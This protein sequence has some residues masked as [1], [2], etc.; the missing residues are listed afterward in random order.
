MK[1]VIATFLAFFLGNNSIGLHDSITAT[2]NV[3]EKGHVVLLK[4]QFNTSDYIFV[5]PSR[6]VDITKDNFN[7]Y[8][9]ATTSWEIDGEVINPK[10]LSIKTS[11]HHTEVLCF[12]SEKKENIKTVKIKNEFLLDIKS[13]SNIVMLD[14][15]EIAK[16]Y[17][18]YQKRR[19]I[20]V[21]YD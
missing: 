13:H 8:L 15:N 10:V 3:F 6:G 7:E 17:R 1:L 9:D 5:K 20:V 18:L 12:M 21:A 14:L 2:F 16:D 4:I 11:K 19:E